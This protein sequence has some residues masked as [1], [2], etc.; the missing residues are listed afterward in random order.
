[1]NLWGKMH[2]NLQRKSISTVIQI[3]ARYKKTSIWLL[4]WSKIRRI[5]DKH[6]PSKP[7]RTVSS[8]SWITSEIRRKIRRRNNTHAKAKKTGSKKLR[9]KFE[10]LRR[11]TKDDVRKQHDLYVNNLVGDVKANPRDFYRYINSQKKDN[12][13]IP[14]L[15]KE[16]RNWYHGFKNWTGWGI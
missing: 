3:F 1:M 8:V 6:I 10:T 2:L 12:Q 15:K 4:L 14:P 11:E 13:G 7:S 16:R 9:S 5:K